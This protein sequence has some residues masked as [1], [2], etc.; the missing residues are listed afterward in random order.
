MPRDRLTAL[1]ILTLL[2]AAKP[3]GAAAQA[4]PPEGCFCLRHVKTQ[5]VQTACASYKPLRGHY[6]RGFCTNEKGE[7]ADILLTDDWIVIADGAPGCLP[8]RPADRSIRLVPRGDKV[9][10]NENTQ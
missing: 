8:C 4:D 7:P 2:F 1:A 6:I 10:P 9:E 5:Q 3:P